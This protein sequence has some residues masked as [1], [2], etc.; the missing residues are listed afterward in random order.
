MKVII[1]AGG[2]GSR[3][4]QKT[5]FVPKPMLKIG[6]FPV[7]W[8]IMKIYAHYGYCD[9]LIALGVMGEVIKEYFINYDTI[10]RDFSL[11][12]SNHKITC[13]N[14][15]EEDNWKVTLIDTGL[16]T[17]KG[18][19][20]KRLEKYLD[21]EVN[22]L[23]YGDGVADINISELVKFHKSHGKMLTISGV[24]PPGRFGEL[25]IAGNQVQS[26]TEK[27]D[28]THGYINGGFMVFNRKL[29]EYLTEDEKCDFEIGPLDKLTAEGQ[30]MV[31][32]HE[33]NWACMD[34]ERDYNSLNQ[35]W[36]KNQAFWKVW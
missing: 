31:Y 29:L 19:R 4:G 15:C 35:L 11:D 10:S 6:N 33:R 36:I 2:W 25:T 8:H 1:L 3:L 26:F 27:P 32:K 30:V 7:L 34:N 22:M 12:L 13:L 24:H 16:N 21:S 20:I 28:A 5:E 18:G 17:L 14:E 23:T 9:F